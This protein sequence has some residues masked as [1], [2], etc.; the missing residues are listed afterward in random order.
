MKRKLQLKQI[1]ITIDN[2]THISIGETDLKDNSNNII[3][4]KLAIDDSS[5]V[6]Q[7][8]TLQSNINAVQSDVDGNEADADNAIAAVQAD[9][10]QNEADADTAI[11]AVQSDVDAN[12]IAANNAIAAVQADV[13]QNELDSDAADT[14]LSN[15]LTV[16]EADPTT[17]TYVD[18]QIST[19]LASEMSY[20]GGID[21][22]AANPLQG[23]TVGKGDMWTVTTAGSSFGD[24]LAVGDMVI[25]EVANA[26]MSGL[27][28]F[29]LVQ[30]NFD[31]SAYSTTVQMSAAIAVV[32][33]DV[34]QNEA[35]AD[36]AIAAL[37]ADVDQN[38]VD[39][40]AVDT[41]IIGGAGLDANGGYSAP[42]NQAANPFLHNASTL[43]DADTKLET[44]VVANETEIQNLAQSL[45]TASGFD[46]CAYY[47][48]NETDLN[49]LGSTQ[50]PEIRFQNAP[51][52]NSLKGTH[53]IEYD[54]VAGIQRDQSG[55][56]VSQHSQEVL[57]GKILVTL[58]GLQLRGKTGN[59]FN[60]DPEEYGVIL[61]NNATSGKDELAIEFA[62][63]LLDGSDVICIM[64]SRG[65]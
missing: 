29:T 47:T 11:A 1:D 12:E 23:L 62:E 60:A 59:V 13:D 22:S 6:S 31:L 61:N 51:L 46:Y 57:L 24:A 50:N 9:V 25:A 18:G 54:D 44:A 35:D 45:S 10:D 21:A 15:R 36:A 49:G 7:L 5:L 32:Q 39:S 34:D 4:R 53:T 37:Q 41:A 17:K 63:G 38:E 14:A 64:I 26:S 27:S 16:L 20:R 58:N 28:D 40:D 19:T 43:K 52:A 56:I 65:I 3:G 42:G 55:N 2:G 48:M 33:S 8:S 30:K